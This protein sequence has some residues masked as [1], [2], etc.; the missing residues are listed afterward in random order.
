MNR[1]LS[2]LITGASVVFFGC[3]FLQNAYPLFS[4][5]E[6][7]ASG[8]NAQGGGVMR[9]DPISGDRTIVSGFGVGS[10]P[11]LNQVFGITG[12]SSSTLYLS[13]TLDTD[14]FPF[15]SIVKIDP[16]TGDRTVLSSNLVGNGITNIAVQ[17][18]L[19]WENGVLLAGDFANDALFSIDTMTGDRQIIS[20][21]SSTNGPLVGSGPIIPYISGLR[22]DAHGMIITSI[23]DSMSIVS[24][25]PISGDRTLISKEGELGSGPEF[26]SP[27]GLDIDPTDQSLIV[28]DFDRE[29]LMRV[30]PLTGDRTTIY[31]NSLP[32]GVA[33]F[34]EPSAV[35]FESAG[36]L[37]VYEENYSNLIRFDLTNGNQTVLSNTFPGNVGSGPQF[38]L[39][40]LFVVPA[41]I[42]EPST[43][44]LMGTLVINFVLRRGGTWQFIH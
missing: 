7:Y 20:K 42:P 28:T 38:R 15:S 8:V 17:Y 22:V 5:G 40:D 44:I 21:S 36:T 3:T 27:L 34:F 23:V 14:D 29:R 4:T 10:G 41:T 33:P 1:T 6:I 30:D 37:L 31:S 26:E 9:I 2:T 16:V 13:A 19:H 25:D 32:G 39:Y 18:G 12:D 24:I 35:E 43:V 11:E